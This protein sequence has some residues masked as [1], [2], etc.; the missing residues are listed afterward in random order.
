MTSTPSISRDLISAWA[1]LSCMSWV[2]F[3]QNENDLPIW[4]VE[5][6]TRERW[7]AVR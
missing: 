6:R 5:R 2:P 4:E 3:L 7:G 1:P